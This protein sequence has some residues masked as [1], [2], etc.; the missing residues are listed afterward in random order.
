MDGLTVWIG[1]GQVAA[2]A[3]LG[4]PDA[5]RR[6]FLEL[7][8]AAQLQPAYLPIFRMLEC[9]PRHFGVSLGYIGAHWPKSRPQPWDLQQVALRE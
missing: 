2:A 4:S 6:R 3:R 8:K 9:G 5:G 1:I 7:E